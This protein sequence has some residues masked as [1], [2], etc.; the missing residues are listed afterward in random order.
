MSIKTIKTKL[1]PYKFLLNHKILNKPYA[2]TDFPSVIQI[3]ISNYCGPKYSK[4]F[5]EYCW[6]QSKICE[7]TWKAGEMPI[8]QI[9]WILRQIGEHG[10]NMW[11]YTLFLNG[12]GLTDVRL[13]NI[14]RLG[15]YHAPNVKNQT[16][17][18][19]TNTENA[20]M[21]CDKNLDWICL[22]LSAP[23]A[24]VYKKVHRGDQFDNVIKTMEYISEN[25]KPNQQLEVHYVIT[26]N[27]IGYMKE[28]YDLMGGK[29]PE[30][31][32]VFSPLVASADNEPSKKAMGNLT[33]KQ[34]ENAILNLDPE[35]KFWNTQTT[36]M[37]QPCVLW[38]NAAITNDGYLLKCC[39]WSDY[40]LH[41]YGNIADYIK[42]GYTL[43]DY[44]A[45]RIAN[46]HNNILCRNCN[47]KHP[48]AKQ[49]LDNINIKVSL[50]Q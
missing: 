25:H 33:L 39:N 16:F 36:G 24:E 14:L 35:T 26:E 9:I 32:R 40:K 30:W 42:E 10:K 15:K 50:E 5:C 22:T 17:T 43:K 37:R 28:W 8:D 7:G 2:W 20:W 46:K 47:L 49:R 34:E 13:P 4:I 38:N 12:D 18:C 29:F 27:N 45:Q 3:D 44:W 48:C 11:Y 19:G 23:N 1:E 6:P 21:L 31:R 41:N